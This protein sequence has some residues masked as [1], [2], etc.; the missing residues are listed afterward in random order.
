MTRQRHTLELAEAWGSKVW[1][2]ICKITFDSLMIAGKVSCGED[3]SKLPEDLLSR[4]S[5]YEVTKKES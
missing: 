5:G 2:R 4:L 3:V 1:C